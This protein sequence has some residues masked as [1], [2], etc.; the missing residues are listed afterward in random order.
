MVHLSIT[1]PFALAALV[2]L[3]L[4][5]LLPAQRLPA[6]DTQC[7]A[8]DRYDM[9]RDCTFLEEHGACLWN[10]LDSYGACLDEGD[11]FWDRMACE[12][13]VQVDLL[14]CNLG[15]PWTLLKS[16]AN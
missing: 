5:V 3:G 15:L 2:F 14:A 10:S 9:P 13:G 16:I 4:A 7:I 6:Q 1:K 8:V 12:V 11:G